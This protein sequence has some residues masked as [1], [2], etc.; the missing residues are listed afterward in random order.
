M[1]AD[2]GEEAANHFRE[3]LKYREFPWLHR[4]LAQAEYMTGNRAEAIKEVRIA[5]QQQAASGRMPDA[6]TAY[7]YSLLGLE[8]DAN[9]LVSEIEK[10][11]AQGQSITPVNRTWAYL[12]ARDY[13]KAYEI[14]AP[15]VNKGVIQLQYIKG[16]FMK[17]PALDVPRFAELRNQ[18][19]SL[20]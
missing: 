10:K 8:D 18:I 20:N 14:L 9:R 11:I 15:N 7:T 1:Y 17:D 19:G 16:N 12:A 2:K 4:L 5:E 6:L 13:D 3:G